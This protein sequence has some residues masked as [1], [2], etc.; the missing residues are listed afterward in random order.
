MKKLLLVAS[1]TSAISLVNTAYAATNGTVNF[2][3]KL[4]DQTCQVTLNDGSSAS[5]TITLR[6]VSKLD[7]PNLNSTAGK[8]PFTLK[9]TGCK[10]SATAYGITAY[11]PN[12]ENIYGKNLVNK[13]TGTTAATG[14]SLQL[15]YTP[16]GTE[17]QIPLGWSS[18][19]YE[20]QTIPANTTSA[21][22]NYAVRYVNTGGTGSVTAGKVTGVAIYEL[23]YK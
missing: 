11:F 16:N 12:N 9:I 19:Q 8:T 7:L 14:V 6:T 20:F 15:L 17:K 22:M 10:A 2:S 23:A 13:A 4:T 21:T 1:V 18:G 3:G 5:G